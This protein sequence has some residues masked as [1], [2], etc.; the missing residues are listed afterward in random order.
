MPFIE[1]INSVVSSEYENS[2]PMDNKSAFSSEVPPKPNKGVGLYDSLPKE[3]VWIFDIYSILKLRWKPLSL[4]LILILVSIYF[5]LNKAL[6]GGFVEF[7]K[8]SNESV[9]EISGVGDF[10]SGTSTSDFAS[11]NF[12]VEISGAVESPGVY[13]FRKGEKVYD[14]LAMAGALTN[15]ASSDWVS[16]HLLLASEP[17]PGSKIYIPFESE[18]RVQEFNFPLTFDI[19]DESNELVVATSIGTDN[20]DS[21]SVTQGTGITNNAQSSEPSQDITSSGNTSVGS[22]EGDSDEDVSEVSNASLINVNTATLSE[23]KSLPGIGDTYANRIIQNRPYQVLTDLKTKAS[24]P[25]STLNKISALI[26][27]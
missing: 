26:S 23:L 5:L 9:D 25:T 3:L 19:P 20:D 22:N 16:K 21:V 11:D 7:R 14:V 24:I 1:N 17:E 13:M 10:Y 18:V 8:N 2:T 4:G 27:Y 15:E 12:Y 6:E